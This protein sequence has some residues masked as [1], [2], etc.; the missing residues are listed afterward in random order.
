MVIIYIYIYIYLHWSAH[1]CTSHALHYYNHYTITVLPFRS[2]SFF[3]FSFYLLV[4]SSRISGLLTLFFH[5]YLISSIYFLI[6]L[7]YT[8]L[9]QFNA[10]LQATFSFMLI[11]LLHKSYCLRFLVWEHFNNICLVPSTPHQKKYI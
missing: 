10:L 11:H 2:K 4:A 1:S 3:S 5:F 9:V 6:F 7:I 8:T